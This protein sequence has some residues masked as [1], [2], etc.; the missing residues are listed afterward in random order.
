MQINVTNIVANSHPSLSTYRTK[1]C[2]L[3]NINKVPMKKN[4]SVTDSLALFAEHGFVL[5]HYKQKQQHL[6]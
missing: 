4:K 2:F 6:N 1:C 3:D 5:I